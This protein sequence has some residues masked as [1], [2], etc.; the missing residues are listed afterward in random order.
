[1]THPGSVTVSGLNW[2][3]NTVDKTTRKIL[4]Q[5]R[6]VSVGDGVDEY[7][8]AD[9]W[10]VEGEIIVPR[11]AWPRFRERLLKPSELPALDPRDRGPRHWRRLLERGR[12]VPVIRLSP[13][14]R[15]IRP[16]VFREIVGDV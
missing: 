12:T 2:H 9:I 13:T 5:H 7:L 6:L 14:V 16:A 4:A 1:M 11:W 8:W 15:R 3:W 10:R